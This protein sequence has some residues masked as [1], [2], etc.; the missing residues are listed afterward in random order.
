MKTLLKTLLLSF[1]IVA[2]T[3]PMG[4]MFGRLSNYMSLQCTNIAKNFA[5]ISKK[6]LAVGIGFGGGLFSLFQ[7][8]S[9][10]AD[11]GK[12]KKQ[13]VEN[14]DRDRWNFCMKRLQA[15]YRGVT[16]ETEKEE[17]RKKCLSKAVELTLPLQEIEHK[18]KKE[19]KEWKHIENNIEK[20]WKK[21]DQYTWAKYDC[22]HYNNRCNEYEALEK[23]LLHE[24]KE[25][26]EMREKYFASY[27][28]NSLARKAYKK[29]VS[30]QYITMTQ[31]SNDTL[32]ESLTNALATYPKSK[33]YNFGYTKDTYQKAYNEVKHVIND[34]C[35]EN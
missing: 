26:P 6:K 30:S 19:K 2:V 3:Q 16:P 34:I 7:N 20:T 11:I 35:Y 10:Y 25:L 14:H 18:T 9:I 15:F 33:W 22:V 29:A 24:Y 23:E 12:V 32:E 17:L 1:T 28:K 4:N 5:N 31:T 8:K 27:I 21:Y 13:E